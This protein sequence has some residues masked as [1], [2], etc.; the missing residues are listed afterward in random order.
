MAVHERR[1]RVRMKTVR[2][3]P[4]SLDVDETATHYLIFVSPHVEAQALGIGY[5]RSRLPKCGCMAW[6]SS[7]TLKACRWCGGWTVDGMAR[8]VGRLLR[9]YPKVSMRVPAEQV[10][11]RRD[12]RYVAGASS[13]AAA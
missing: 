11:G 12:A 3:R 9:S 10:E 1:K 13:K 4:V 6:Q 2:V 8:Y 7:S 5:H